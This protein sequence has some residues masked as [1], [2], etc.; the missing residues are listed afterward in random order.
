M[1]FRTRL[2]DFFHKILH[3]FFVLL[4]LALL[5]LIA[6][7]RMRHLFIKG[8]DPSLAQ[9]DLSAM[10]RPSTPI[11]EVAEEDAAVETTSFAVTSE[12]TPLS[13]GERLTEEGFI[14]DPQA[15]V[16][17]VNQEQAAGYFRPGN[18]AIPKG[19]KAT[20]IL[21]LLTKDGRQERAKDY[22][23]TL[24]AG[25]TATQLADILEAQGL[26]EDRATLLQEL[27]QKDVVS[28]L[29][30]GMHCVHGPFTTSE[31]LELLC[32]DANLRNSPA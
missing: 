9:Q 18:Y 14:T 5:V 25:C 2:A 21:E 29:V 32:S 19:A 6:G 13:I 12:M 4:F 24:P 31:L 28:R 23:I 7:W 10:F 11:K 27:Q 8:I 15:F 3:L 17:L 1:S 22:E 26:I 30:P 20:E 16:A